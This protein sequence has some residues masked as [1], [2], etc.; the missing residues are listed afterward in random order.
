MH[1]EALVIDDG[2]SDRSR[3]IIEGYA[4]KDSCITPIFFTHNQGVAATR[5]YALS[6]A[7]GGLSRF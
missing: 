4:S 2:S 1:W 7:R 5:N 3:A 6:Q